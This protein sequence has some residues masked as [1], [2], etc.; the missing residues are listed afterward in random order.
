MNKHSTLSAARLFAFGRDLLLLGALLLG[1]SGC[2]GVNRLREAQDSFTAAAE[3]E[4]RQQLQSFLGDAAVLADPAQGAERALSDLSL[5][6]SGYSAALLSL[7]KLS[8]RDQARLR[9]DH[10]LGTAM[11][12]QALAEWRLGNHEAAL[13]TARAAQETLA[14]Q[15][16]PRDAAILIALKGLI[17]IDLAFERIA[18]MSTDLPAATNLET[19]AF[20][21]GRL[22]GPASG[23]ETTAIDDLTAA[24]NRV[25]SHHPLNVYLIQAQ[26]AAYRNY[27]TAYKRA[28][29]RNLPANDPA[30][31]EAGHQL[32]ELQVLLDELEA[33]NAGKNLVLSWRDKYSINPEPR[34]GE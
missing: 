9:D 34:P 20:V 19:L 4:N 33:G 2:Q 23:S 18:A 30:R 12:L 14:E 32:H 10:L 25:G 28:H 26:L 22:V 16:F 31:K 5:A 27:Q 11:T 13:K 21:Q 3:I 15:I 29:G 24:R 6:R 8:E 17:K 7:Q 1:L